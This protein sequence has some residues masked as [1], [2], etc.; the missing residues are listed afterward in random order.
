MFRALIPAAVCAALP[1]AAAAGEVWVT[2]DTIGRY[3]MPDGVGQVVLTNPSVADVQ[4]A[5]A[6]ELLVFGRLPG[7]TDVIFQDADGRRLSQ[8]RIR[9]G[10]EQAGL[11]TLY[12]GNTR[13]SF[14]CTTTCEQAMVVGDGALG[15]ANRLAAQAQ[16]KMLLGAQTGSLTGEAFE[17]A[18]Q[19]APDAPDAPAAG[20]NGPLRA[21]GS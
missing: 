10:N 15:D 1:A 5:S 17:I 11:V 12:N 19:A 7:F 20:A 9:V 18:P 13:Y 16:N 21:P 6:T 8:V 3:Q 2:M 4:V 14:S